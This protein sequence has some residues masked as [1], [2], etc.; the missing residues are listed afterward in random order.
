MNYTYRGYCNQCAWEQMHH[1]KTIA[2]S[3]AGI[4]RAASRNVVFVKYE[5]DRQQKVRRSKRTKQ[6]MLLS[7]AMLED[8]KDFLLDR[9]VVGD[10]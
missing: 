9:Q 2:D 10:E 6:A 5:N 1:W 3:L 7:H 8:Y 4:I